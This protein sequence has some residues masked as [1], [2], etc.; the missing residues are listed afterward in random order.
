MRCAS[1]ILYEVLRDDAVVDAI[2]VLALMETTTCQPSER[3]QEAAWNA[4]TLLVRYPEATDGLTRREVTET[5][6]VFFQTI[7]SG[8]LDVDKMDYLLRD[9][10]YSGCHYGVY[11][12]DHLLSTIRIGFNPPGSRTWVGLAVTDKG[13][14]PLEDFV[15]ARFQLYQDLYSHKT[16]VGFK[17]LLARAVDE[18]MA[19]DAATNDFAAAALSNISDF[20]DFT[21][22]YLWER[23]R[24][25]ARKVPN[26]AASQLILRNR[27]EHVVTQTDMAPFEKER[28]VSDL[29]RKHKKDIV[30]Y[31]SPI[32]FSKMSKPYDKIRILHYNPLEGRRSLEAIRRHSN[33]FEKFHD[34]V[35]THFYV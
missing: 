5:F 24:S 11:N 3:F 28:L 23:L 6:K 7:I 10:F 12:L 14:V 4:L 35:I 21:D 15:Y 20:Q 25:F 34:V 33:F 16:V 30:Y 1:Q 26:C 13:I 22:T 19:N 9:S 32:S 17:W 8:E 27:L 18:L 29:R 31:E 2:D